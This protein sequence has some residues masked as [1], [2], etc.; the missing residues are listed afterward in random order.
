MNN[1]LTWQAAPIHNA[2]YFFASPTYNKWVKLTAA[3]IHALREIPGFEG[4]HAAFA[5]TYILHELTTY[6]YRSKDL[7]PP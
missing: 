5:L 6:S 7:L 3:D 2:K 4:D 1:N